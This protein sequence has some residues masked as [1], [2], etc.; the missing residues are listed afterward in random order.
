MKSTLTFF[1]LPKQRLEKQ[2]SNAKPE[3]TE[4]E[5]NIEANRCLYC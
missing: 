1:G 2:F 4:S 3:L 5:A